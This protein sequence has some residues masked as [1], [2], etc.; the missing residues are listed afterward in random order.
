MAIE[1]DRRGIDVVGTDL[2]P[3]MLAQAR[4]KAPGLQW[5]EAD[6]AELQ[7]DARFDLI[8][9]AGNVMI[10]VAEGS[11]AQVTQRMADHLEPAGRLI[12]GFQLRPGG[13][14]LA[15]FDEHCGAAGLTLT[16]RW[17][18]WDSEP[19]EPGN[20]YAVSVFTKRQA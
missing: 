15:S 18:T 6:L 13:Y 19:F 2:D 12:T 9:A 7:L 1:L 4:S 5:V 20:D 10:F 3:Q 8:V 16:D 17:S 14:D 11:E